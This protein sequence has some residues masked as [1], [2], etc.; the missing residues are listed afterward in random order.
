M[1]NNKVEAY[2]RESLKEGLKKC[3]KSQQ[4]MFKRM[5]ANGVMYMDIDDVVNNMTAE[6]LERAMDQVQRTLETK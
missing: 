1:M 3:N 6:K 2:I 5:Y 4:T